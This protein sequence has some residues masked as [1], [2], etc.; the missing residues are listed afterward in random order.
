MVLYVK[1]E[2]FNFN[3]FRLQQRFGRDNFSEALKL[4]GR[5]SFDKIDWSKFKFMVFDIPNFRGT[6][7]ERYAM[8]GAF[9]FFPNFVNLSLIFSFHSHSN[10]LKLARKSLTLFFVP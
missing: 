7:Q 2:T 5:A 4:T 3:F 10:L 6:Y 1:R 8:L 9:I